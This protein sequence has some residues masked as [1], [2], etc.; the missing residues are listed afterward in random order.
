M[1][2]DARR[3]SAKQARLF[4]F[5]FFFFFWGGGG[6]GGKKKRA[7]HRPKLRPPVLICS[8]LPKLEMKAAAKW[9]AA[10][11]MA[12]RGGISPKHFIG[13]FRE[14]GGIEGAHRRRAR[15][16]NKKSSP[17]TRKKPGARPGSPPRA[18]RFYAQRLTRGWPE[19]S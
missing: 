4:F 8:A 2:K 5:F 15:L 14:I 12:G 18:A 11:E 17:L 16:R 13:F 6:G 3:V 1:Y 19:R 9:A 10:V 7:C